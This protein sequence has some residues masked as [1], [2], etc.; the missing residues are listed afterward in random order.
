MRFIR[1]TA[2]TPV[3]FAATGD[4]VINGTIE[5]SA[6]IT[7]LANPQ[8]AFPELPKRGGGPGGFDGGLPGTPTNPEG[9]PGGGP[10]GGNGG[11]GNGSPGGGGGNATPGGTA[12]RYGPTPALGG[13]AVA[14]GDPIRGGSG[15]GGGSV[16]FFYGVP[17]DAGSGGGGGGAIQISTPGD[18]TIN[19]SI[20]ANGANGAW[21]FANVFA[22]GG[23]G[24][25]GSGGAIEFFADTITLGIDGLIQAVGGYGGGLSTQPY[26]NDPPGFSSHADGGMG[27]AMVQAETVNFQGTVDAVIIT[28]NP[29]GCDL[30]TDGRC[31][32]QDWLLFG[33]D[34]G[35]T[36]CNEVGVDCECDLNVDG[37][38][39]MQD[40]LLFGE[41]WGRTDCPIP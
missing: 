21:A 1:N 34:W 25:G 24:G 33:E 6:W 16:G 9:N 11:A 18:I 29:C 4:V 2:N 22:S 39:D 3:Y 28:E 14:F 41:D 30:N 7:D 35:R 12:D 20:L 10:G 5:V 15:G 32:M 38:C 8:F 23:P 19:S 40:W 31:D 13:P 17:L 37:T 36:D 27:Y 26:T